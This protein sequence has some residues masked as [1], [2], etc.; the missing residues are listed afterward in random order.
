MRQH[1]LY[2][3][4]QSKRAVYVMAQHPPR[5]ST[6]V[7]RV[8]D[9][10]T[11]SVDVQNAETVA[12]EVELRILRPDTGLLVT[13]PRR[14]TSPGK[15]ITLTAQW[16]VKAESGISQASFSQPANLMFALVM[17]QDATGTWDG[18]VQIPFLLHLLPP[19]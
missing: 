1:Q 2:T 3:S 16:T 11:V 14:V 6:I 7:K 5:M 15:V 19:K 8:G 12:R 10:L 9:S 17:R 13:G 18:L 4:N